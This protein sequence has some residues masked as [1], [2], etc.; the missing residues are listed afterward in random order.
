M[1]SIRIRVG[2][3]TRLGEG[4]AVGTV[5]VFDSRPIAGKVAM[6]GVIRIVATNC[7]SSA[8]GARRRVRDEALRY[9]DPA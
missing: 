2:Q 9:L 6:Q 5:Y 4:V 3:V 8:R 1:E 7:P